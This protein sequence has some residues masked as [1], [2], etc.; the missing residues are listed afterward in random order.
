MISE[1]TTTGTFRGIPFNYESSTRTSGRKSVF[2]TFPNSNDV[3]SEDLGRLPRAFSLEMIIQGIGAEY[4]SKRDALIAAL[5]AVGSGELNHPLYGKFTVQIDGAYNISENI[6]TQG[7]A[8]ISASF[9][10]IDSNEREERPSKRTIDSDKKNTQSAITNSTKGITIYPPGTII[11]DPTSLNSD[12]GEDGLGQNPLINNE[13]LNGVKSISQNIKNIQNRFSA[14]ARVIINPLDYSKYSALIREF[15]LSDLTDIADIIDGV[16]ELYE[17]GEEFSADIELWLRGIESTYDYN[18]DILDNQI[19]TTRQQQEAQNNNIAFRNLMQVLGVS[20]A[21]AA[22]ININYVTDDQ[23]NTQTDSIM[24]QIDK[25]SELVEGDPELFALMKTLKNNLRVAIDD[26]LLNVFN[27]ET[28]TI[29]NETTMTT[30]VHSL[31]GNLDN[32]NIIRD[33]N[34]FNNPSLI[35]GDIKVVNSE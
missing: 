7:K 34:S 30:L 29:R 20:Y 18:D 12:I 32:Y 25:V 9:L 4:F 31:Y 8:T 24:A 13:Y 3:Q 35:S 10:R 28:I 33:L 22:M 6:G 11:D 16:G 2:H 27:V 19:I 14:I 21:A 23:L 17:Q 15:G 26:E 1:F 5:D